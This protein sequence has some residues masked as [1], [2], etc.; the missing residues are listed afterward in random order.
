MVSLIIPVYNGEKYIST[1]IH[2]L[3]RQKDKNFE[4]IFVN[5][6]SKDKSLEILKQVAESSD[7]NI[8]II[9]QKNTGVSAARNAGINKAKGE[10]VCFCDV[11]DEI[12]EEYISAMRIVLENNEVDLV[13][14]RHLSVGVNDNNQIITD[15]RPPQESGKTTILSSNSC[16]KEYLT[17]KITSGCWAVMVRKCILTENSILFAEGYKYGEDIHMMWRM[18]ACSR[19]IACLDK[20]L[21][22]YKQQDNSAMSKVNEEKLQVY[23]LMKGLE[24]FFVSHKPEFS[25]D[26]NRYGA[27]RAMWSVCWQIAARRD[28]KFFKQFIKEN[29]VMQEMK[30]LTPFNDRRVSLSARLFII[31]PYLFRIVSKIFS[32]RGLRRIMKKVDLL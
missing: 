11:D 26:Y 12:S 22:F 32:E 7:I 1:I 25:P 16:L 27:A 3:E 20:Y 28:N 19:K 10:A 30:K 13:I 5:D 14:C 2:C 23:Q 18:I 21:Y 8:S 6:G 4:A 17:G 29:N 24:S 31:S 15:S 9:D